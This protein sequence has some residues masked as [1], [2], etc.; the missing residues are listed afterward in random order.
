MTAKIRYGVV[1]AVWGEAYTRLMAEVTLPTNLSPGNLPALA[2]AAD[3]TYHIYASAEA[4][5]QLRQAQSYAT[6]VRTVDVEL[7][8]I[9]AAEIAAA[10][11][12]YEILTGCHKRA[13]AI[14][15]QRGEALVILSPDA[16]WSDGS[17][18]R[19][20]ELALAGYRAVMMAAPRAAKSDFLQGLETHLASMH[21][22]QLTLSSQTL[23]RLLFRSLHPGTQDLFWREDSLSS[24][25]SQLLWQAGGDG[26]L[27][28]S[29]H[30][31]P[32]LIRPS[33]WHS[34]MPNTIDGEFVEQ[35]VPNHSQIYVV[36]D[37]DEIAACELTDANS[38]Q[39]HRA[40]PNTA[41]GTTRVAA[42]MRRSTDALHRGFA[43]KNI[44]LHAT[45][46]HRT[47]A[48]DFASAELAAE[49]VLARIRRNYDEPKLNAP[50]KNELRSR[51]LAREYETTPAL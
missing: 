37:S 46:F 51:E 29:F 35:A 33:V 38:Q 2:A 18:A 14:A 26:V 1:V 44:R 24:W 19:M 12:P 20:H 21:H 15:K 45:P 8:T 28:R 10:T 47:L 22:G 5:A 43:A 31:H 48:K 40:S 13:I 16:I 39:V 32:L 30:L 34:D 23:M 3:V 27:V 42:W 25:P 11:T 7:H 50:H 6:L 49:Q 9:D 36:E 41:S 17:F 4:Q